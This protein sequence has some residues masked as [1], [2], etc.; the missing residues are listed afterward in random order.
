MIM[1]LDAGFSR[2]EGFWANRIMGTTESWWCHAFIRFRFLDQPCRTF[3]SRIQTKGFREVDSSRYDL[4]ALAKGGK[5]SS[6]VAVEFVP[7]I[8][9]L[10]DSRLHTALALC[11][12]WQGA[13]PYPLFQ[14]ASIWMAHRYGIP[15][16]QS[17]NALICSEALAVIANEVGI[18]LRDVWHPTWDSVTPGSA[19]N[20][21]MTIRAGYGSA[22]RRKKETKVCGVG[23]SKY[24]SLRP[25]RP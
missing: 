19:W 16:P 7:L 11:E 2:S 15:V 5:E 4:Q 25:Q 22:I 1:A 3:E 18:D 6:V 9:S 12:Q 24:Y 23:Y 14:L 17:Q 10:N 13:K 20:N 8:E 21:L